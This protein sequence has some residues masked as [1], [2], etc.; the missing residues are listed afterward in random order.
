MSTNLEEDEDMMMCCASCGNAAVDDIQL[1]KCDGCKSVRYCSDKCQREHR[2]HHKR[3]CKKRA[4]ELRDEI[5]FKQPESSHW[6]DCPLCFLPLALDPKISIMMACCSK[7]ICRGCSY[8][9]IIREMEQ[10]IERK[11]PFCRHPA[12]KSQ[13]EFHRNRMKRVEANDPVA[14]RVKG[15]R[16]LHDGD[17]KSAFEYLSKAAKLGDIEAHNDLS[18]LYHEGEGVENDE[19]KKMYHLEEAAIGGHPNA[20]HNL[21]AIE[22]E[23]GNHE[24]AVKHWIIAAN[25]GNDGSL[26]ALKSCYKD[27]LISKEDFAAALRGHQAAVDATKSPQREAAEAALVVQKQ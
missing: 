12:P 26:D 15:K 10:K 16:R 1:K 24:R 19:K 7:L 25:L 2:P 27:G 9:N 4:A 6:G 11:C 13:E 22:H 3:E 21:G 20:R 18:T 23:N 17:Y 5:L 14:L 8:A